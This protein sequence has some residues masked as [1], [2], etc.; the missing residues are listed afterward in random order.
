MKLKL[1]VPAAEKLTGFIKQYKFV[2]LIMLAG[3]V[4]LIL[5]TKKDEDRSKETSGVAGAEEDFSVEELEEK[6]GEILSKVD[7]AGEVSVML[8][9]KS[10]TERILATDQER[11]EDEREREER[12]ETV[13]LSTDAG[14]E[15]VLIGQNYPVFQ[16]ALIVCQGGDD[17]QVQLKLITAVSALTGLTS[18]R[19]TVCKGS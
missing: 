1:N 17:P 11:S 16:G 15:V 5:P 12:Q 4:L 18:N 6:L 14:E 3:I 9:V 10:G 13:I 8:T 2:F 7:G 19:I